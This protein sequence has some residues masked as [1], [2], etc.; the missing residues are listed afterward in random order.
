MYKME[1]VGGSGSGP[2]NDSNGLAMDNRAVRVTMREVTRRRGREAHHQ[3]SNASRPRTFQRQETSHS[4]HLP[5]GQNLHLLRP[6]HRLSLKL[7][8]DLLSSDSQLLLLRRPK[9][10]PWRI[11]LQF[12]NRD[13]SLNPETQKLLPYVSKSL[14]EDRAR[15][16]E[17]QPPVTI[18]APRTANSP[19]PRAA[20][21]NSSFRSF[22][23]FPMWAMEGTGTALVEAGNVADSCKHIGHSQPTQRGKT[24]YDVTTRHYFGAW[25]LL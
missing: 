5:C 21:G 18:R 15:H 25:D 11:P 10:R 1:K 3:F 16:T 2:P 9:C 14:T 17:T 4:R 23:T 22:S 20:R 6:V 8:I 24:N 19:S 7:L 12:S 13:M